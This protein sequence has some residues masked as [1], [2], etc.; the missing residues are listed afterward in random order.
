M[1][2]GDLV[3]ARVVEGRVKPA[4][5]DP[6]SPRLLARAEALRAVIIEHVGRRRG[7]LD[8]AVKHVEGDGVDH[9]LTRG[10]VKVAL[11]RAEFDVAA[12]VPPAQ[13]RAR[14][15][16]LA[17]A[18]G[19][20]AL[21]PIAGGRPVAAALWAELGAELGVEPDALAACLYGDHEDQQVLVSVDVPSAEWLLHRYNVALVQAVLLRAEEL[22]VR[23]R[24]PTPGRARQLARQ[25]K[26]HQLLFQ[27]L[28]EPDGYTLVVDGPASIFAQTTR[29][30]VALARLFPAILLQPG[31]WE[32]E[33]RVTWRNRRATLRL[34]PQDGLRS[35]YRDLGAYDTR[36]A[37]WFA[38]RFEA[39]R[40]GWTLA[41]DAE[42]IH[43][44]GEA[45]VVP[46]F[47]FRRDGRVAHLEILGFWRKA[48]VPKRLQLLRRHGPSNLVL[49]VSRR[50][51]GEGEAVDLPD[52]V[53]PFA[54]VIPAKE[55]LARV[56]RIA[57]PG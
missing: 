39:L 16:R 56:E 48:T 45:V 41:R 38:E 22:R 13:V 52:A 4:F 10:L 34:G 28:P 37:A 1:L 53:V 33:A 2:T 31:D 24:A 11:D 46:D 51:C 32:V 26:F 9:K 21:D 36:E 54:E 42:P 19:P 29:Y 55:V 3:R 49:A 20:L 6:A 40:S 8:E 12:P 5:V 43:Q 35:H 18:R 23:L 57:T 27:M 17:R 14:I 7:E 30:G 47:S 15:F 25:L 44:G 50:L